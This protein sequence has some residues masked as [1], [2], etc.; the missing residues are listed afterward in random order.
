MKRITIR[1]AL[2]AAAVTILLAGCSGGG[3]GS[4]G[5]ADAKGA[6]SIK[7]AAEKAK[8]EMPRPEPGLY[9]TTVTMTNID[10][11]GLPP[12]MADHGKGMV[13]TTE[14]CL[15]AAD[16]DK[17]FEALVKQGQDGACSYESFTLASG[18]VDAVLVC[19]AQGRDTRT[20]LSGTTTKTG[21]DLTATT[22]MDFDG[23]GKAT[24][25][26]TTKHER[27]GACPAK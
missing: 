13:T 14:N 21:A 17:G 27:I 9:K 18:K 23:V 3:G 5:G 10:M 6:V 7:D 12:E 1:M 26:F 15:T 20:A 2:G 16:V 19:K 11:P 8:R 24:L 4:G 22:A 25:N